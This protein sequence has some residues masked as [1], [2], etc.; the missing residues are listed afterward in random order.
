MKRI[1]TCLFVSL[2]VMTVFSCD[3]DKLKEDDVKSLRG[4]LVSVD[5]GVSYTP[6]QLAE[7][8]MENKDGANADEIEKLTKI[9][10]NFLS[11]VQN[12]KDSL[13]RVHGTNG[14]SYFYNIHRYTYRSEDQ[15]GNRVTLSAM[16][17]W[18]YY[19]LPWGA[20]DYDPDDIMLF[21]HYTIGSDE[22]APTNSRETQTVAIF[23]SHED[24]VIAPDLI[25]YG[26][27]RDSVH[28]YLN[29]DVTAKNSVDAIQAGI[30]VFNKYKTSNTEL[31]KDWG[32]YVVGMSQGGASAL[33]VQKYFDTHADEAEKFRFKAAI[34]CSGPYSP[35]ATIHH[36]IDSGKGLEFP[37]VIPMT[38]KSMRASYPELRSKYM[39][40]EFYT[41]T[42][43][44]DAMPHIDKL[45]QYKES[46]NKEISEEIARRLH[47]S[48]DS[49]KISDIFNSKALD[50]NSQINKDMMAA[51][52]KNDLVTGWTPK[53]K[54]YL[55]HGRDDEVVPYIN[56]VSVAA[57][58][59]KNVMLVTSGSPS[60]HNSTCYAFLGLMTMYG[61]K[62]YVEKADNGEL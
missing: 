28:L 39:E 24:L 10:D 50:P 55:M 40:S 62:T 11:N 52:K 9:R 38:T 32:L 23:M 31:E 20:Y 57:N 22:E 27:T 34:C 35:S 1:F 3:R 2:A 45:F 14:I 61:P 21:E 29:H 19:I 5:E 8:L 25:G 59:G 13:E 4:T 56:A 33:A 7:F 12:V 54:I 53:H 36:Y 58:F 41:D 46:T 26:Q 51:L 42:Y 43:I 15:Y 16:A 17:A 44:T 30:D 48:D 6:E 49:V 60:G 37:F 47:L 18:P